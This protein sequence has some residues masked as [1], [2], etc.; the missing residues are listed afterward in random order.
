MC[1]DSNV[2]IVILAFLNVIAGPGNY[3]TVNFGAACSSSSP[4][5]TAKGATGL[6]S[7]PKMAA[8]ITT[9]QGLGK[10]VMLSIGGSVGSSAFTSVAEAQS[11][12]TKV[13]NLFGSGTGEDSDLRPFGS[14]ILDGIDIGK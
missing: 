7:C 11:F 3:P 2:D 13:W 1:Q 6:L 5:Q 14:T 4:A 10:K 8:D 12:A 9:C